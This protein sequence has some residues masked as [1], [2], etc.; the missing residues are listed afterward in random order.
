MK[1]NIYKLTEDF[2]LVGLSNNKLDSQIFERL[3]II[4]NEITG[5][6]LKKQLGKLGIKTLGNEIRYNPILKAQFNSLENN[7]TIIKMTENRRSFIK[8]FLDN[9]ITYNSSEIYYLILENTFGRESNIVDGSFIR[10]QEIKDELQKFHSYFKKTTSGPGLTFIE[11]T[12]FTD[13]H[14]I[15][16]EGYSYLQKK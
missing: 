9:W 13:Y 15:E 8:V 12:G 4:E 6:Y 2:D 11:V 5:E 16:N 10:I 14:I 1:I 7:K 3:G